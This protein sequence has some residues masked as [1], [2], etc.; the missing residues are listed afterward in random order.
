MKVS[1]QLHAPAALPPEERALVTH[2]VWGW[3]D[4][5]S[6]RGINYRCHSN[7]EWNERMIT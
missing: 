7:V 5:R 6:S 1:C 3:V 2:W 4:S